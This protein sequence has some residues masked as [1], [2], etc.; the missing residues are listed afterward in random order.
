[1]ERERINTDNFAVER[2]NRQLKRKER[3]LEN[4]NRL[5]EELIDKVHLLKAQNLCLHQQLEALNKP[6]NGYRK[7]WTWVRKI[8]FVLE[9]AGRPMRSPEIIEV[10]AKR[11]D[12][13][14]KHWNQ[15]Q[16]FSALLDMAL[17]AERIKR[18]KRKGE[19]GYYYYL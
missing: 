4:K 19:R 18:E 10:L 15:A 12:Y 8:V 9:E 3:E 5:V 16:Y 14:R 17:K 7:E 11:E 1:M 2:L 6:N 13:L